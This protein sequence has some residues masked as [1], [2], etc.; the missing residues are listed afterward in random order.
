MN[1][2]PR[3]IGI[4]GGIG[5]GKSTVGTMLDNFGAYVIDT[6][7]IAHELTSKGSPVLDKISTALG[8][9]LTPDGELDRSKVASIVFKDSAKL[10]VLENILHPEIKSELMKRAVE[11]GKDRVF[12]LI[13]LLF[14]EKLEDTVD[15]I[16][17]CYAGRET[18]IERVMKRD[19][20]DRESVVARMG[21]QIP[22]DLKLEKSDLVLDTS[23]SIEE[24]REQVKIAFEI[25][26]SGMGE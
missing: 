19:G 16:W 12:V 18:R 15:E 10:E 5:S 17:L 14:E 4:T 24:V 2:K 21:N 22:D 23:V 1:C 3:L 25:L 6:D 26:E 20:V 11:S 9:V 8:D 13:P 7:E